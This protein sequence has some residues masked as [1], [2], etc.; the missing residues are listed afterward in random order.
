MKPRFLLI[1]LLAI[2]SSVRADLTEIENQFRAA[3][4]LHVGQQHAAEVA[5]LDLKYIGALERA[6]QTASQG[7][8]LEDAVFLREEIQRVK[9]KGPLP[10]KDDGLAPVLAKL[11]ATYRD[12]FGKLLAARQKA[13]API[14]EKFGVALVAYQEE[15]TK[16]GK[17]DEALDVKAY[18]EAGL[19]QKLTG[20]AIS[21]TATK[22][23]PDKPF[24]NTLG[25]RFVPVP[26]TGG[27][28]EGKTI[29]FSIWETRVKDY[30]AFAE[31]TKREWL[32]TSLEQEQTDHH[33]AVGVS[34]D[35]ATAFCEWLTKKERR[36]RKIG[37]KD[38]YRLPA[39]H[40]WSCAVGI[41]KEEDASASP[42]AENNLLEVYP[43]GR[44]F[45]PPKGAGNYNGEELKR[46]PMPVQS[47][48]TGYEDRF[49]RTAPVGSFPANAFG[50][51]DLG[52][53]VF[54]WCQDWYDPQNPDRRVMRGNSWAGT[55]NERTTLRSSF[56]S[57]VPPSNRD[58]ARGFR[59]VLEVGTPAPQP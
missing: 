46:N 12:Q 35:D 7:G 37:P 24:E 31:D 17:L 56:R 11:R 6:M 28:S 34:W 19:F 33:P 59:V 54:E 5:A 25:M 2:A 53:N 26:I 48:I 4:E 39:D 36:R 21:L 44:E 14:I 18:R 52:G 45:P 27:P 9:D 29:R 47:L 23:A 40:E 50:I 38:V 41:G 20:D 58:I 3:Y 57:D 43:W 16:A 51:F 32:K 22:A 55:G 49:D 42:K 1:A 15:L 10:E 13:V 8:K 30:A